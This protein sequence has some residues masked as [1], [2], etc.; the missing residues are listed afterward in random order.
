MIFKHRWA[1]GFS[2][3]LLIAGL[4]GAGTVW[5]QQQRTAADAANLERPT[6][7]VERAEAMRT[8]LRQAAAAIQDAARRDDGHRAA[9]DLASARSL[10]LNLSA[11]LSGL[12]ITPSAAD[13]QSQT[14]SGEIAER[15]RQLLRPL[16]DAADRLDAGEAPAAVLAAD[17]T[18][19]PALRGL[20]TGI[21]RLIGHERQ[22]ARDQ[23]REDRRLVRRQLTLA[24]APL[25]LLIGLCT[26]AAFRLARR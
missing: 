26:V 18:I 16:D 22:V 1:L 14:M 15:H 21:A 8:S 11:T 3:L 17:G 23:V 10:L 12:S 7:R 9:A 13:R 25:L 24:M 5:L 4:S 2:A 6:T 19:E 20:D